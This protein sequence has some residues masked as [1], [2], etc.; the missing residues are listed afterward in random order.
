MAFYYNQYEASLHNW[1]I[2]RNLLPSIVAFVAVAREG[3]FTRAAG[4]L[5]I[6]PSA[7]SQTIRALEE[8]LG[9]RLLN[10]STRSVSVTESGRRLLTEV[11]PGLATIAVAV[12]SIADPDDQPR[13]DLRINVPRIVVQ[14][15]IAPH[16][17]EFAHRYTGVRLEVLVD[18]GMGD[19][20][21]EDFDAGI[22]LLEAVP[23]SMIA[24]PVT[25]PVALAV[26][27]SPA[28]FAANPAP[29]EPA[30]LT[31]HN[32]IGYRQTGSAG[33]YRWE[34]TNP[35]TGESVAVEPSGGF[36]T[37]S[38]DVM[39]EA[40]L[41]GIGVVMHMDF[42]VR[43]HIASGR[44]MR[45]MDRWCPSFDGFQLYIPT[46]EQ[47]PAKLRVLADFLTEKR[48]AALV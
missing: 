9:V 38:D 2:D 24:I 11:E 10:R 27:A 14:H 23:D 19:I 37:N 39:L 1:M 16:L 17:A 47:M 34:F 25:S 30:D 48:R 21:R 36:V 22:R 7:L 6:T 29:V 32:C 28:Y 15:F 31:K 46:R 43:E 35:D 45:V 44:L 41:Q 8:R 20:V 18:D 4:K 13:G 12:E 3:G 26:V 33:I 42:A 5:G 40:A